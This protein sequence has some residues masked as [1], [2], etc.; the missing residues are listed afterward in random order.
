MYDE[1]RQHFGMWRGGGG[2]GG[3]EKSKIS[4]TSFISA[5]TFFLCSESQLIITAELANSLK[6]KNVSTPMKMLHNYTWAMKNNVP[7][8]LEKGGINLFKE[9]ASYNF[10]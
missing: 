1:R 6:G 5:G 7:T 3:S 2:G 10:L 4:R 8:G 9:N